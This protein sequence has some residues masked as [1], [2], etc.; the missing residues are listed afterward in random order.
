[1]KRKILLNLL[2]LVLS[3]YSIAGDRTSTIDEVLKYYVNNFQFNGTVL[4]AQH[5]N[6]IYTKAFGLANRTWNI[7][8]DADTKFRIYSMSKAFTSMIIYQLV[9]EN[10]IDLKD[11]LTKF[12]PDFKSDS[13]HLVTIHHLLTHTSGIKDYLHQDGKTKEEID[14]LNYSQWE[15][16][17]KYIDKNLE[18]SPGTKARYS[19]SNYYLL[20]VIIEK[21]TG[22]SYK[23]NVTN[24][25]LVPLGMQNSGIDN[26]VDILEKM[27]TGY[28]TDFGQYNHASYVNMK[29]LKGCGSIY[30]TAGDLLKWD[31]ALY[32][33][34]LLSDSLKQL[35]FKPLVGN[36][37]A[38]GWLTERRIMKIHNDTLTL[39]RHSG[40][41]W[42]FKN[43]LI[44]VNNND[45]SIII[46]SNVNMNNNVFMSIGDNILNTLY[47]EPF[48]YPKIPVSIYLYKFIQ[49]KGIEYAIQEYNR[50][51]KTPDSY[52]F[53]FME[54]KSLGE[55]LADNNDQTDAL[56]IFKLNVLE[57]PDN[58][59]VYAD[60]AGMYIKL[61]DKI[62]AI[63]N[64]K[65][66]LEVNKQSNGFEKQAYL[67]IQKQLNELEK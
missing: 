61:D 7:P 42:G 20:S 14:R 25:I 12:L 40:G 13:N 23:E 62:N 26:S 9:E 1:M 5:G 35:M 56:E 57:Y 24:R 31:Q 3:H 60:L 41:Y 44:R 49:E 58:W 52:G 55:H 30:S 18:F 53:H 66:S 65:R 32:T 43:R 45:Y 2:V 48:K 37:F 27:S 15:F 50:I 34:K 21:V 6:P 33:E 19:N 22:K 47:E 39:I 29:N 11:N 10:K 54:L 63:D 59:V 36:T 67:D 28:F 17:E 38:S 51:K 16:I 46:L 8:N 64:L 4:I